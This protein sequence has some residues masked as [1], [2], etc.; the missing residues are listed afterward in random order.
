MQP[1]RVIDEESDV[2]A[3]LAELVGATKDE[4][5]QIAL[6]AAAAK[7]DAVD[8]DPINA[9]G[10]FSYIFGTRALRRTFRAKG[11]KINRAGGVE[12]VYDPE[13][14]IKIVFQNADWA[15]D[16]AR[17]PK[18]I[19]DKGSA[20]ERAVQMAQL[21]LFP[22][23][24]EDLKEAT[25]AIWYFFVHSDNDDIRAELSFPRA[26]VD[27]QFLGFHERIFI[28]G[29]GDLAKFSFDVEDGTPP[30]DFEVNVTRK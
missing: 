23:P 17:D 19:S 16:K 15:A 1:A 10:T 24:E 4:L 27:K 30:Q 13:R 14:G 29:E 7:V 26:I 12:S 2:S 18:A 20:T 5:V 21:T 25:A 22:E 3:R 8:D 6:A 9:A 11:W 28:L